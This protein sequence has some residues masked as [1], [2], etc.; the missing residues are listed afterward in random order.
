MYVLKINKKISEI[1]SIIIWSFR[2]ID[3]ISIQNYDFSKKNYDFKCY[4]PRALLFWLYHTFWGISIST[5]DWRCRDRFWRWRRHQGRGEKILDCVAIRFCNCDFDL[6]FW[7]LVL[8]GLT[9]FNLSANVIDRVARGFAQLKLGRGWS[10]HR[11]LRGHGGRRGGCEAMTGFEGGL[12][13]ISRFWHWVSF[14]IPD[15]GSTSWWFS[16]VA[17]WVADVPVRWSEA[18]GGSGGGAR[19]HGIGLYQCL[20]EAEG[21]M[22]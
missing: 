5:I 6:N 11:S 8:L 7:T 4:I 21:K 20:I 1:S 14:L 9:K 12:G 18:G 3:P 2:I 22:F 16:W 15:D 17:A 13:F 19:A 10:H